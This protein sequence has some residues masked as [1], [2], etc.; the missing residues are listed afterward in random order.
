MPSTRVS[1]AVLDAAIHKAVEAGVFTRRRAA[2]EMTT[3]REIMRAI[4]HA[5][6]SAAS[7]EEAE[8]NSVPATALHYR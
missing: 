8:N 6:F 7:E 5:A 1:E 2:F 3:N 4:L